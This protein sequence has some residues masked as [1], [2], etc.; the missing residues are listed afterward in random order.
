MCPDANYLT[1]IDIKSHQL[2]IWDPWRC[3]E[4]YDVAWAGLASD[5]R[6]KRTNDMG[7]AARGFGPLGSHRSYTRPYPRILISSG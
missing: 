3:T 7:V 1:L 6:Q 2:A 5:L 4:E